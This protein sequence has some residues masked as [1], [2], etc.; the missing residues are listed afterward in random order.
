[1]PNVTWLHISDLHWRESE[2]YD[3]NVVAQALL[4]DLAKRSEIAPCLE[5]ID[6]IFVTGDI[7]FAS[8]PEE[9]VLAQ[10]FLDD[11]RRTTRVR[12][13]HLFVVPGNHDVDRGA[14][15]DEALD[16]V[17][18]CAKRPAVNELLGNEVQRTIV[19]QR[20][21]R[22]Q[23]FVR[24]YF[25][26]GLP[27][28]SVRYFYV[29]RRKIA[30]NTWAAILGLNSAW[31]S[32]SDADRLNLFL[33]ER[34]V[35]NA[36]DQVKHA[37]I[38]IALMHH[39]F[40]WLRDF[41]RDT[42]EPLLLDNCDFV[43]HGH[44]HRAGLRRLQAP[45]SETMAIGAGACY[46][47]RE[48]RNA[49]NLVHLD[50]DSAKGTVHLRTYSD[51]GGGFWIQDV[52]TYQNAPGEHTF[53]LPRR[54]AIEASHPTQQTKGAASEGIGLVTAQPARMD[55]PIPPSIPSSSSSDDMASTQP[56]IILIVT[57]TKVETQAVLEVLPEGRKWIRQ[58]IGN[59]TY[60]NLGVHGGAPVFM[61][62]SEM[63]IATPGG[64][65]LTVRQ[66]IQDLRPQAVIMCGIAFGLHPDKQNLGDILIAKQLHYYE[67][68]KVDLQR[69]QIP[70][71]DRTTVSERLLDRFR[72]GDLEWKGEPRTHF[73]LVLSGEKLVN[74]P[75]FRD[76]LLK[77]EPEALGG[78]ME[79]AGLYAAA[80]DAKVD[81][82][83]IKAIC[84]WADGTK[85]DEV[86]LSAA[87]NAARFVLRVLQLGGWDGREQKSS[88][89]SGPTP[90]LLLGLD[91]W[92]TERGYNANPFT[93]SNAADVKEDMVSE[94]F[95][96]WH[97]D[98]NTK[99]DL[100]GL[101]PTPTLDKAKSPD[102]SRLV[103]IYAPGGG[104]KTFY[105][106]WAAQQIKEE[107]RLAL[108]IRNIGR[109][110]RFVKK[111]VTVRGL[112]ACIYDRVCEQFS[113]PKDLSPHE[114]AV[115]I[116]RKCDD[117]LEHLLSA[118]PGS[119]RVYILVDDVAQL[120][121]A[122][123]SR[124]NRNAQALIALAELCRMVAERGGGEPLALRM[125]VPQQ[126]MAPLRNRLPEFIDSRRIAECAIAWTAAHCQAVIERRLDSRWN[127]GPNTGTN[128][129]S[130]L[131]TQ[132]ARD[133]FLEW[134]QD[135]EDI[136]PGRVVEVLDRLAFC[137]YSRGVATD[138]RIGVE[139]W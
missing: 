128:H 39:P 15:S 4:R 20:F 94:L 44:L 126:L 40:D 33:G 25:G 5:H 87:R 100:E 111:N 91:K 133:E 129:L 113:I 35:R 114:H 97:V 123:P 107:K 13:D 85:N 34:Q 58:V 52:L 49:Y 63:G 89:K 137:A 86:Q 11:L 24:S 12:K 56:G 50:F 38:R 119:K 125:F 81:W 95:H 90:E 45:G 109:H 106:R 130:R 7:A 61:V 36:L 118:S 84:D 135:Q 117:A 54:G 2:A 43:L 131:F 139:L 32:A 30:D 93:W 68:Q 23:A 55:Q 37:D 60:Y 72:S 42:C 17:S 124:K 74:A 120:F 10:R 47:M 98:P 121:D 134:L 78:E 29:K 105:R 138:E 73:G 108:E 9:Y 110:R 3:A 69:G 6:F 1:V 51:R 70:R 104:G 75:V 64:T 136:S 19:M 16:I 83:V 76:W 115:H 71:G 127:G 41:D 88:K 99:A 77:N 62:Q 82:I 67:P 101:G 8:K 79:G 14:I 116:L 102:T 92:W 28:D 46:D 21:H 96:W 112:A 57:A 22:Y 26:E 80:R 18:R 66:A 132:D 48:Y 103:L 65:L 59:K 27:F 31:A 122:R 53:D